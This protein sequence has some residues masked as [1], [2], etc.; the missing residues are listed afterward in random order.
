MSYNYF[1]LTWKAGKTEIV[2]GR[3]L[4]LALKA[5]GYGPAAKD[6]LLKHESA[7]ATDEETIAFIALTRQAGG[8]APDFHKISEEG[9]KMWREKATEHKFKNFNAMP[10]KFAK[11]Q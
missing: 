5:A 2:R 6:L 10:G 8:S 11:I 9:K 4:N 7:V 3:D 1:K